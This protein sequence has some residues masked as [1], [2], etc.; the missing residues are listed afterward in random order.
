VFFLIIRPGQEKAIK[1][2]LRPS[3][4]SGSK[5]GTGPY[6]SAGIFTRRSFGGMVDFIGTIPGQKFLLEI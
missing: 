5:D 1:K 2:P 6:L 4:L 3:R